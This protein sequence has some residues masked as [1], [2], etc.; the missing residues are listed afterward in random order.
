MEENAD[1]KVTLGTELFVFSKF[2]A[3]NKANY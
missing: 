1:A 3:E 2:S